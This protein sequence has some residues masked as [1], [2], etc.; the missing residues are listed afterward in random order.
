MILNRGFDNNII[1]KEKHGDTYKTY[2]SFAEPF[3]KNCYKAKHFLLETDLEPAVKKYNVVVGT[4]CRKLVIST[5][6]YC[7]WT[8]LVIEIEVCIDWLSS[9]STLLHILF[10]ENVLH[11]NIS[12]VSFLSR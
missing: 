4:K 12:S 1:H 3:F 7:L 9:F 5:M 10:Q 6:D 2:E 11:Q 8:F